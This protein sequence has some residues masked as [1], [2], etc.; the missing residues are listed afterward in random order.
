M[1]KVKYTFIYLKAIF[2]FSV[3]C[4]IMVFVY[5]GVVNHFFLLMF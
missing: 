2:T 1:N 4:L 5:L 3:H